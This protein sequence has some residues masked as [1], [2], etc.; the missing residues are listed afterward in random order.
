MAKL[1]ASQ[2]AK[3]TLRRYLTRKQKKIFDKTDWVLL[4][5][6]DKRY[7]IKPK[8]LYNIYVYD[9][10]TGEKKYGLCSTVKIYDAVNNERVRKH[11]ERSVP[12]YDQVL[13]VKLLLEFSIERMEYVPGVLRSVTQGKLVY[14]F[15]S[16]RWIPK[17][18]NEWEKEVLAK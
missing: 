14:P 1:S 9:K 5:I 3:K 18:I 13:T 10:K 6:E 4:D 2:N 17:N 7:L 12:L 16:N 15:N 11:V 8:R